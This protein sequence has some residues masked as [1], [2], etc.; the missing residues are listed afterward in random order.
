MIR[1][2]I[3]G[4]TGSIGTT[5]LESLRKHSPDIVLTGITANR[6][7]VKGEKT[8]REFNCPLLMTDGDISSSGLP[9]FL[10]RTK[11][12]IVLNAISGFDGLYATKCV[13]EKSINLA[14]ANKESVVCG[15]SFIFRLAEENRCTVIPVD[16]EHSAIHN[17]LKMKKASSLVITASGGPFVDRKDLSGV[18]KKDALCHPTWKMGEKITIDSATLANKGMEVIEASYLFGFPKD[19]IEVTVH[20][21]SIVHSMIRTDEGAVYAQLSPPDMSL[22]IMSAVSG[23]RLKLEDIVRPLDF[24]SL[25]LTFEKPDT[26]RFPLLAYA[27]DA[28]SIGYRGGIIYNA[29]DEVAVRAFLEDRIPF[30]SI[31]EIVRLC[32]ECIP[33]SV[34]EPST[35]DEV[36]SIDRKTRKKAE[37]IIRTGEWRQ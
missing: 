12:D 28:L 13:L 27:Y 22:P 18:T 8:A 35:Y 26:L 34:T 29:S 10:D 16:S 11:P 25:S 21:Q 15:A 1:L 6:N 4:A 20:R 3:L 30:S 5:C 9:H 23:E 31:A 14:L 24:T 36:L 17:L 7:S 37:E 19:R 32:L 2:V 33:P